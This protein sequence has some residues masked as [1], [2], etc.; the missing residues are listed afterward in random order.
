MIKKMLLRV[1]VFLSLAAVTIPLLT[2]LVWSFCSSWP[3]PGLFPESFSPRG[4]QALFGG[5]SG[6]V[7]AA[8]ASIAIGLITAAAATL[9]SIPA[10]RALVLH[11]FYGKGTVQ[12]LL[13]LPVAVPGSAF[14]MSV[15][16]LFIRIGLSDTYAGVI[17][18]HMVLCLPYT[19]KI[20]SEVVAAVGSRYEVQ[21][22]VL[23]AGKADTFRHI[24]V[25]VLMPGIVSAFSMAFV[26]SMGQYFLTFLIG[27]GMVV[28]LPMRMFPYIQSG[29]R[30][31]ASAYGV[32]FILSALFVFFLSDRLVRKYYHF[33]STYFFV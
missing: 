30:Q 6:A 32:L 17:L 15:Q 10:A 31:L 19:V 9:I 20:L 14:A 21:A 24:T 7:E 2:L 18:V 12:L 29:D 11:D 16:V 4:V 5:Y 33:D 25:P 27:G 1:A 28:T 3:W 13:L 8:A 23:G 22:N 26:V